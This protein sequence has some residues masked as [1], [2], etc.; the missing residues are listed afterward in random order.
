MRT[1]FRPPSFEA[2]DRRR[3]RFGRGLRLVSEILPAVGAKERPRAAPG[4]KRRVAFECAENQLEPPGAMEAEN[5]LGER[6]AKV[7]IQVGL[8]RREQTRNRRSVAERSQRRGC[9]LEKTI[10]GVIL[11]SSDDRGDRVRFLMLG[12]M[13]NGFERCGL[14]AGPDL[15][16]EALHLGLVPMLRLDLP[17]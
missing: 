16:E 1:A 11:D 9:M 5:C 4:E 14:V 7:G 17:E 13:M 12:E 8:S 6:Q 3:A 10:R 2:M 15:F